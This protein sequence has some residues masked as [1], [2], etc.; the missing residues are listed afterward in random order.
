MKLPIIKAK[1]A[2]KLVDTLLLTVTNLK[3]KKGKRQPGLTPH[4]H[5]RVI[6]YVQNIITLRAFK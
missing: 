1:N 3:K 4:V 5:I 2:T 6:L